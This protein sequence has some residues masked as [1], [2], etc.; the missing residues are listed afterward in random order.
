MVGDG[1]PYP[2]RCHFRSAG[3]PVVQALDRLTAGA[4]LADV[5]VILASLDIK[6]TEV[7]R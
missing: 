1:T 7:D 4:D 6:T 3:F 2:Y 5:R